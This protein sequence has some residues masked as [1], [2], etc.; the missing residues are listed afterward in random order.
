MSRDDPSFELAR[1]LAE[2][3]TVTRDDLVELYRSL[4]IDY[5]TTPGAYGPAFVFQ[6]A[7]DPGWVVVLPDRSGSPAG[8][9]ASRS[10][11]QAT[12]ATLERWGLL[13]SAAAADR[14]RPS[15]WTGYLADVEPASDPEYEAARA[16]LGRAGQLVIAEMAEL[17]S[18]ELL[19]RCAHTVVDAVTDALE[20]ADERRSS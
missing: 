13:T 2:Q 20:L 7:R 17:L 12:L 4:G 10:D 11:L 3:K 16:R 1:E 15:P 5:T 18:P 14:L 19:P 6:M 8:N 9:L